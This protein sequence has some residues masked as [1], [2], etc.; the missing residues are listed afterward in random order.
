MPPAEKRFLAE[1]HFRVGNREDA[2]LTLDCTPVAS[3]YLAAFPRM[4]KKTAS[5]IGDCND[6]NGCSGAHAAK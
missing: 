6:C 3:S 5:K 1:M 2:T 4:E